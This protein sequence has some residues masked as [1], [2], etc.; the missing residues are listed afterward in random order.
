L[1]TKHGDGASSISSGIPGSV[2][3]ISS[4]VIVMPNGVSEAIESRSKLVDHNGG[5]I[6]IVSGERARLVV[7]RKL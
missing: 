4:G 6:L 1:Q 3:A 2:S 7:A 5:F